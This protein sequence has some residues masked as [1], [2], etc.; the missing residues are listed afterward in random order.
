MDG[1]LH[2]A[3]H[4]AQGCHRDLWEDTV[5]KAQGTGLTRVNLSHVRAECPSCVSVES[6]VE[7]VLTVGIQMCGASDEHDVEFEG[8]GQVHQCRSDQAFR[9]SPTII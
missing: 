7:S 9:S 8:D 5:P 4:G 6:R 3:A 2:A 1:C